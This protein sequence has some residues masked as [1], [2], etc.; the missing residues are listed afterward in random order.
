MTEFPRH[1]IIGAGVAQMLAFAAYLAIAAYVIPFWDTLDW[2]ASYYASES[3]TPW[4]WQQHADVRQPVVKLLL[5]LDLRLFEGAFYP[6][7]TVCVGGMFLCATGI[8]QLGH[9]SMKSPTGRALAIGVPYI[10]CFQ[11]F[12]L[13]SYMETSLVQHVL[14]VIFVI[15]AAWPFVRLKPGET[16]PVAAYSTS[17]VAAILASLTFPNGLLAWPIVAWLAWRRGSNALWPVLF[18]VAGLVSALL[19]FNG[20]RWSDSATTPF[21]LAETLTLLR[22]VVEFFSVPWIRVPALYPIGIG[23]GAIIL[24]VGGL[25]AIRVGAHRQPRD[26]LSELAC[27]LLIFTIGTAFMIAV[28]RA[29]ILDL[30]SQGTR[31]GIYAALAQLAVALCVL[32]TVDRVCAPIT[33]RFRVLATIGLVVAV[34][35]AAQQI[36]IGARA[37][38]AGRDM[39]AVRDALQSGAATSTDMMK[40]YPDPERGDEHI[41]LL[42]REGLYGLG[43]TNQ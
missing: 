18:I 1:F 21:G 41:A 27:A 38:S 25:V 33:T 2:I 8:A 35:L 36:V 28:A 10:L 16:P 31:Y 6:I 15:G 30:R 4:L 23:I 26:P 19:Y 32:P 11:S 12:T 5:W 14:V 29:D 40:I 17:A 24:L 22:F 7:A 42:K 37:A 3:V 34:G 39:A 9:A 13:P 20:Y 43:E